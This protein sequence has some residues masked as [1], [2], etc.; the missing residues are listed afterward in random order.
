MAST[1]DIT[2]SRLIQALQATSNLALKGLNE[3]LSSG[4]AAAMA[5]HTEIEVRPLSEKSAAFYQI[6][7]PLRSRMVMVLVENFRRYVKLALAHPRQSGNEP[8]Q[9]AWKQLQPAV[10]VALDWIRDW[11]AM[12]KIN[13]SDL[14]DQ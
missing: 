3:T 11:R 13:T 8:E 1:N 7:L 12:V 4:Q 2:P 6:F 14:R 9:W 5:A 10:G